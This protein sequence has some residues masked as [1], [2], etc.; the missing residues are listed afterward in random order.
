MFWKQNGIDMLWNC[1]SQEETE[2]YELDWNGGLSE[3]EDKLAKHIRL[4]LLKI[5]LDNKITLN[6]LVT[7]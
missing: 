3:N 6:I 2:F 7:L 4:N 1:A 5:W